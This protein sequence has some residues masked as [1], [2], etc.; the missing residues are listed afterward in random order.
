MVWLDISVFISLLFFINA[1]FQCPEYEPLNSN[2]TL[3]VNKKCNGIGKLC[4]NN[5]CTTGCLF[6]GFG[7]VV[8]C[9]SKQ[10]LVTRINSNGCQNGFT[11][12]S[13]KCPKENKQLNER[14]FCT[15]YL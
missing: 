15:P 5:T 6:Y 7:P 9:K 3:C 2:G 11:Y 4:C 10:V 1:Q 12:C 8:I 13:D 14:V